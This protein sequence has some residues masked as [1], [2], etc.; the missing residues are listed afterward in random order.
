MRGQFQDLQQSQQQQSSSV[1]RFSAFTQVAWAVMWYNSVRPV[2]WGKTQ[3]LLTKG[4]VTI[5]KRH[6]HKAKAV[7]P[8]IFLSI[9]GIYWLCPPRIQP[10]LC[11][12]KHPRFS[13]GAITP[14]ICWIQLWR[15]GCHP[16]SLYLQGHVTE[17]GHLD[18]V[19][20][21]VEYERS[22][23][24]TET[25]EDGSSLWRSVHLFDPAPCILTAEHLSFLE[26]DSVTFLWVPCLPQ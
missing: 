13:L 19:L 7:C 8:A 24:K 9:L 23:P 14:F 21:E 15:S 6:R 16:R 12:E 17:L 10:H 3:R 20:L 5:S 11:Q 18:T 4:Y 26:T 25:A 22:N 2:I 1:V